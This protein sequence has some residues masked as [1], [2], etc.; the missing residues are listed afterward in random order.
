MFEYLKHKRRLEEKIFQFMDMPNKKLSGVFLF[1]R[2]YL[3]I[4]VIVSVDYRNEVSVSTGIF[5]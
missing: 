3:V 5:E 1:K 4:A 2:S